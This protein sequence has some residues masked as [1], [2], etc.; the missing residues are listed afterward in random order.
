MS[1]YHQ[2]LN[3][4]SPVFVTTPPY[5]LRSFVTNKG[6]EAELEIM[7]RATRDIFGDRFRVILEEDAEIDGDLQLMFDVKTAG[8]VDNVLL[9]ED[10][11]HERCLTFAP[12]AAPFIRLFV[13]I[14]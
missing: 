13:D 3:S 7:L 11:W 4:Q 9:M 5:D 6:I 2:P 12:K 1:T 8:K 10:D 14:E